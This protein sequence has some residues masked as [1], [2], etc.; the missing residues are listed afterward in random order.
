M[1]ELIAFI[2]E[3]TINYASLLALNHDLYPQ[4]LPINESYEGI[5]LSAFRFVNLLDQHG[6]SAAFMA[7]LNQQ[8]KAMDSD[9]FDEIYTF[10]FTSIRA[11][12][13]KELT[14]FDP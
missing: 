4:T 9:S 7:E 13:I 6:Y 14:I 1:Q 2:K 5:E 3:M 12:Y 8:I 10:I 11:K